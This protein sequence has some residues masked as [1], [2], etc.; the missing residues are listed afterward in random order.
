MTHKNVFRAIPFVLVFFTAAAVFAQDSQSAGSGVSQAAPSPAAALPP[1]ENSPTISP[2]SKVTAIEVA[3]NKTISSNTIIAKI[4]TKVGGL[5]QE[6]V[7]S[8]DIKRLYLLGFFSDINTDVK[9]YNGGLKLVITVNER[10]LIEKISFSG[11]KTLRMKED[12]LKGM[13]KSKEAQYL[14]HPTLTDDSATLRALYEKRGYSSAKVEYSVDF[15]KENGKALVIFKV[16]EGIRT[17]IRDIFVRGAKAYKKGKILKIMKTRRAWLFN[18]GILKEEVIKED[19]DRLRDFYRRSGYADM[20]VSYEVVPNKHRNTLSVIVTINEGRKYFVGSVKVEGNKEI[21][22][23]DIMERIK[24]CVPGKVFSQEGMHEDIASIQGL[25]FDKGYIF[26]GVL[27]STSLSLVNGNVDILYRIVENDIAYVN[28]IKIRGNVKTRD[29]V[30]RR[31]LRIHPGDRFDGDKLRRSKERLQNLGFFEEISYDTEDTDVPNSKD[32]VVDVKE[33]KT[34]MFSFGGG[35]SSVDQFIGFVEIEQRNFDWKNF[36]YFTG[37]GQDLKIRASIGSLTQGYELS[38][39]QPW[40]F[41]YPVS[42]GFDIYKR[43]HERDSDVGYGYDEDVTGGDLRLTKELSEYLKGSV[44]YKY[45]Q[46]K[47]SNPSDD[48]NKNG[49][50][51]R[52]EVG[53]YNISSTS[54]GLT[55]DSRDNVFD[56]RRGDLVSGTID[57]AGGPFGGDKDFYKLFL[58]MSHYQPLFM[59]SVIELRLRTGVAEPYGDSNSVPIYERYF[60]GGANT[61]RGYKERRIGPYYG[62]DNDDPK[63]GQAIMVANAEYTYPLMNFLRVAFFYDIGNVWEKA[64]ELDSG[65]LKAGTGIGFRIKTPIGP[66]MLDYGIPLNK[67]SGEDSKGDGRFHFNMS[68]GF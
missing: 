15:N 9:P 33:S 2:D 48:L 41:D 51:I 3:G 65:G 1:A 21:A 53:K 54:Y 8:D 6:N 24:V 59:K 22:Q 67:A 60:A 29:I 50:F 46:I 23:K 32:L 16:E 45:E 17:K 20:T 13:I 55:Y 30:I 52:D 47:I 42:F 25:Y 34:G 64:S 11:V 5:Y 44:M 36:P 37:G 31:E 28:K 35:Y 66:I 27:E 62:G 38:F 49:D 18:S 40:I 7:V 14:D 58:R 61:I 19:M 56:P 4:K 57:V 10:P 26:A 68:H 12:K 63:G 39:T 43:T